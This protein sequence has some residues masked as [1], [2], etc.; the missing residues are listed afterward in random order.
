[1]PPDL[2]LIFFVWYT[3][4]E[5]MTFTTMFTPKMSQFFFILR[6]WERRGL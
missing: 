3:N 1:M 6:R 5:K 2:V 4:K